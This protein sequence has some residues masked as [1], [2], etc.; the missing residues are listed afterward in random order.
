MLVAAVSEAGCGRS[1]ACARKAKA[2]EACLLAPDGENPLA[3][4]RDGLCAALGKANDA[5]EMKLHALKL[6][7]GQPLT[8]RTARELLSSHDA[9]YFHSPYSQE[10]FLHRLRS[11]FSLSSSAAAC[12]SGVSS[13]SPA[14]APLGFSDTRRSR[15]SSVFPLL[16]V[17]KV[18]PVFT[19][20]QLTPNPRQFHPMQS[21]GR[22][23]RDGGHADGAGG[24]GVGGTREADGERRD[25]GAGCGAPYGGCAEAGDIDGKAETER[26]WLVLVEEVEVGVKT[27][28]GEEATESQQRSSLHPY[29]GQLSPA[30][31]AGL[32]KFQRGEELVP[33]GLLR[34]QARVPETQEG[35]ES[36]RLGL[37]SGGEANRG[38]TRRK[39]KG[40]RALW[41]GRRSQPEQHSPR[42]LTAGL[43]DDTGIAT[44]KETQSADVPDLPR[45]RR[46]G[47]QSATSLTPDR[48]GEVWRK[49]RNKD[50]VISAYAALERRRAAQGEALQYYHRHPAELRASG[51]GDTH[52]AK[53]TDS[54]SRLEAGGMGK[55]DAGRQSGKQEDETASEWARLEGGGGKAT[56][57]GE[58]K[59]SG[60]AAAWGKAHG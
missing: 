53:I 5:E 44:S 3:V 26:V 39:E 27:R 59:K 56:H 11:R 12:A 15:G 9:F 55:V 17:D 45:A 28:D 50:K 43:S 51:D 42:P 32:G 60:P 1:E 14:S 23:V 38:H 33:H 46:T 20:D 13:P 49:C 7:P 25:S 35:T 22:G 29:R 19:S 24:G 37:R 58:F 6:H 40:M 54:G 18:L 48:V 2:V 30:S 21:D 41:H 31:P 47:R 36:N 4:S 57:E 52:T 10:N 34:L 16:G 8:V